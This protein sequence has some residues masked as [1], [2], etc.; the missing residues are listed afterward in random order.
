MNYG[1]NRLID[2]LPIEWIE[3]YVAAFEAGRVQKHPQARFVN[4]RGECC[5]VA[6]LAGVSTGV[7]LTKT[8]IW[9]HFLGTVLEELSCGF[10]SRRL[11]G[12][13]FYEEAVLALVARR[14]VHSTLVT[15]NT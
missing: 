1:L 5:I 4:A 15:Q 12:Q 7:E 10:E 13:Q 11:T 3:N 6:A 8:P 14:S 2:S 9:S